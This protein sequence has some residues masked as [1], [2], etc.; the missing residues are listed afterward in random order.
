MPTATA[1]ATTV[2]RTVHFGRPDGGGGGGGAPHPAGG[3]C[4]GTGLSGDGCPGAPGTGAAGPAC[5]C[6]GTGDCCSAF[7]AP[8]VDP[9]PVDHLCPPLALAVTRSS[10]RSGAQLIHRI[11]TGRPHRGG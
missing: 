4:G 11:H 9:V 2:R 1:I 7:M 5:G 6:A 8:T 10:R 3:G